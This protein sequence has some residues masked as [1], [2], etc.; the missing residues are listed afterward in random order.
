MRL[1]WLEGEMGSDFDRVL[2]L[3]I[4][5]NNTQLDDQNYVQT[6]FNFGFLA[7]V[8]KAIT[9]KAPAAALQRFQP[10]AILRAASWKKKIINL[11]GLI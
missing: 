9:K 5:R 3:K 11:L 6:T 4:D 1:R 8:I 10:E 2:S 7:G